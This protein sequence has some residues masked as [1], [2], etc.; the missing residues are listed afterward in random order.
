MEEKMAGR[1]PMG[2]KELLRGKV[3]EMVKQEKMTLKDAALTLRVSYRQVVRLCAAYRKEGDA[4]LIHG[5]CGKKSNNRLEEE[6]G[7]GKRACGVPGTVQRVWADLCGGKIG[8]RGR[9]NN[10]R[11]QPKESA[12]TGGGMEREP[13]EERVPE[14]QGAE[15]VFWRTGAI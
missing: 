13:E 15:G 5:N 7:S 4:G 14:P 12:Y 2:Q 8:R 10:E 3:L 1:L 6:R 9:D 11:K